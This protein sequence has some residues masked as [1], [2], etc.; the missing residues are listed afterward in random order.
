MDLPRRNILV[1]I[2]ESEASERACDWAVT[3]LYREG[4]ELHLFHVIPPGQYMVLSTDLGVEG[5]I[6]DDE[7]TQRKVEQHAQELME[8]KFASKLRE[9]HIPFKVEIV[10]FATDNE[11]IGSIICKRADQLNAVVVVLAK[12]NRGRVK[13][14]F[15]GSVA[16]YCTHHCKSPVLVMHCD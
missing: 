9:K 5:V 16:S 14:F 13:E 12:H 7:E 2:D 6:Q 4:D 8:K 11:S 10:K 1:G 3:N 15:V